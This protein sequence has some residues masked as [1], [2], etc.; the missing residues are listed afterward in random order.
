M[1][2]DASLGNFGLQAQLK[3]LFFIRQPEFPNSYSLI[4]ISKVSQG[5]IIWRLGKRD[6]PSFAAEIDTSHT[7]ST[8]T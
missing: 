8:Y 2:L 5:N 4:K 1:I 7:P 3:N 6:P